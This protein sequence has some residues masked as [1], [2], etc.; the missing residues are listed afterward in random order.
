M[1]NLSKLS[2]LFRSTYAYEHTRSTYIYEH[3]FSSIKIVKIKPCTGLTK[4][5][6]ETTIKIA[7]SN[8]EI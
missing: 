5:Y 3:T 8:T 1:L 6:L 2:T 4:G 7:T